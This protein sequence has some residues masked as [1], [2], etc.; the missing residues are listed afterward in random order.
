MGWWLADLFHDN[1]ALLVS[2]IVWVIG[3]ICLHEL[4][5][6]WAA[7][8]MGD[9]TPIESGHM[10]WNPMVHMGPTSLIVFLIIG[11]AWGAM[12]VNPSRLRGR[13]ADAIVAFA[14]PA[15]NLLLAAFSIIALALWTTYATAMDPGLYDNF[16]VFFLAGGFL[17]LVL[18]ALNLMPIPPL[19]GSR[20]VASF[21][22]WFR[23]L[24]DR[25]NAMMVGLVLAVIAMN[26]FGG[27]VSRFATDTV[28]A[29]VTAIR[30][31]LP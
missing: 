19:D 4:A 1:K 26:V 7:I 6:G 14:G 5:H 25:P 27:P 24:L 21:S 16:T 22:P 31:V 13:H 20:I 12:P 2:H 23:N 18:A 17:N 15:M 30:G 10:T 29:C 28:T 3:S 11:F 9:R 8:R